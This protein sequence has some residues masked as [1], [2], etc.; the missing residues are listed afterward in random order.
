MRKSRTPWNRFLASI[1]LFPSRK[2]RAAQAR[3]TR[4]LRMEPLETRTL[5]SVSPLGAEQ[6]INTFTAGTQRLYESSTAVAGALNGNFATTWT[7]VNQD[8]SGTGVQAQ[9]FTAAG[10]AAGSE[11]R[12]NTTTAGDQQHSS[13]A[14]SPD[15]S[16]VFVWESYGQ[17]GDHAGVYGQRYGTAGQPLGGEFQANVTTLGYQQNPAV[18]YL[19]GGGFVVVW[20]GKGVGDVSG[21]FGRRYDSNGTALG[22][23]F[24][25]NTTTAS[26]QQNPAVAALPD[27]SFLVAWDSAGDSDGSATGIFAQRFDASGAHL[28]GEFLVNTTTASFQQYPAIGVAPDGKFVIA[29]QS[30]LQDGSGYGIY[31]QRYT[32]A[33]A[34]L[35]SEFAVNT[36]T[37]NDQLYP[38]VACND[39]GGFVISWNGKGAADNAGVYIR[40]F[41]ADGT[42]LG[43]ESLVNATTASAQQSASVA[44]AGSGYVVAW[45]GNG[46]GDS[47]GVFLRRLGSGP[48]TAGI[49]NVSVVE[50]APP[51]T[52]DLWSAFADAENGVNHLTYG[53]VGNT[54]QSLFTSAAIDASTGQLTLSY[55]PHAF[56]TVELTV[57]A[58]DPGGLAVQTTFTV[59]VHYFPALLYWDPDGNAANNVI[60]TGAGLGGSGV[61]NA[62]SENVWY[63][64]VLGQDVP[65]VDGVPV[66]LEGAAGTVSIAGQVSTG[67]IALAANY[68]VQSGTLDAPAMTGTTISVSS[69]SAAISSAIAGSGGLTLSGSGTLTLSGNNSYS[70]G[71]DVEGGALLAGTASALS[72]GTLTVNGGV[73]DLAGQ[74]ITVASL[75]GSGGVIT[76]NSNSTATVPRA[77]IFNQEM[78]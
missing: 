67:N 14:M 23:E 35:D 42:A 13:V 18:A 68:V 72:S 62:D 25:I 37:D 59:T 1:G 15:G 69:G 63:D 17:D 64:P 24:L 32:A 45:S 10:A 76:N 65:W 40:E 41:G 16:S 46:A 22:S 78:R 56:G 28:G 38:S 34:K 36:F 70:G 60:V 8:G 66:V 20:D 50:N 2:Q 12:V 4:K 61:W 21:V 31:A 33:G 54:N 55:A 77:E 39:H 48:T 11:F 49:G 53:V 43:S 6:R 47:D 30:N 74:A 57:Q 58:A 9:R 19:S 52:I 26:Q 71:T 3:Q 75:N 5:L 51:T 27:G 73:F 7:S 44:A 29:W